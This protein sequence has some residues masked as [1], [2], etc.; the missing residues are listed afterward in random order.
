MENAMKSD[1]YAFGLSIIFFFTWGLVFLDGQTLAFLTPYMVKDLHLTNGQIGLINMWQAIGAA[2]AGPLVAMLSDRIGYRK[3]LVVLA[4]LLTSVFSGLTTLAHSTT[5]LSIMRFLVGGAEGSIM[6]I[7]ITMI[8]ASSSPQRFGRNAGIVYAGASVIAAALGPTMVTQLVAMT[9][10]RMAFLIVSI[11]SFIL[12]F[13]ISMFAKEMPRDTAIKS[14][15]EISR[16]RIFELF[17]YRN[18]ILCVLMCIVFMSGLVVFAAFGPLYLTT[19]GHL[20][21]QSM[22]HIWSLWG[23]VGIFWQ[24]GLPILSD[25]TGRKPTVI[26]FISSL[27]VNAPPACGKPRNGAVF[28]CLLACFASKT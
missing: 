12:T 22:G 23:V 14:S 24:L 28:S 16:G 11:P 21:P 3:R 10:W 2:I 17:K 13:V 8:R 5:S 20:S 15:V 7:A 9:S 25:Y 27:T 19:V 18:F 6:P 26:T 1:K 4:V